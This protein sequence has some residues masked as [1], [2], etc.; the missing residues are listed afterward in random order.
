MELEAFPRKL[1]AIL[2]ADVRGY[3][4]LMGE[5]EDG[6]VQTLAACC[7]TMS[8][9]IRKH[10]GRV[11]DATGD[12]VLARFD[13]VLDAVNAAVEMQAELSARNAE[14]AENR[15]MEF[16]MGIN[17]GDVLVDGDRIYGDGVNIVRLRLTNVAARLEGLAEGGGICI[18]GTVF[19]QVEN[20][21][22]LEYED[23]GG[24]NR[25]EHQEAGSGV[26]GTHPLS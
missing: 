9:L 8:N 6:T 16:R 4:R 18:S 20:K 1:T 10:R 13:S 5:D 12:N 7:E 26:P 11:V 3:S 22:A 2:S 25:Q 21:L 23:L 19:D 15:R 17:L 24:T 14:L